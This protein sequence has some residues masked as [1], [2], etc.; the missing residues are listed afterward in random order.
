MRPIE[1]IAIFGGLALAIIL[2]LSAAPGRNTAL[3]S[4]SGLDTFKL[5]TVDVYL[6]IEKIMAKDD[7]KKVREDT[8]ALWKQRADTIEREM[9]QLEDTFKVLAQNDPQLPDLNRQAQAKQA[10]YQKLAQERQQDLEKINSAQLIESYKRIREATVAVAD[11]LGY[12]HILCNRSFDR[13]M[14][15]VTVATTL[16]ELLARPLVK[17]VQADD[18]TDAVV[19]ELNL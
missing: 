14:E 10:E 3:A 13:P 2:A 1:R 11:R 18:I 5:G 17:G 19:K 9:K 16:Q 12:S 6:A 4:G 15:T 7:M 8:A